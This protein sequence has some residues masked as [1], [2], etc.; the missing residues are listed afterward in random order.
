MI[1]PEQINVAGLTFDI[2]FV[3]QD[4]VNGNLGLCNTNRGWVKLNNS[5]HLRKELIEQV[6]VHELLHVVLDSLY[7]DTG[8]TVTVD[9]RL[10]DNISLLLH[11]IVLQLNLS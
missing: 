3:D 7:I 6:F 4:E 5:S 1:I 10:I 2:K 8:D 11:Q 9:E